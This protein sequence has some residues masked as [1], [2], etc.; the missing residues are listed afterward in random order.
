MLDKIYGYYDNIIYFDTE[1]TG[2]DPVENQIIELS[3]IPTSKYSFDDESAV[4]HDIY[5]NGMVPEEIV[6]LTGITQEILNEKGVDEAEM[7]KTF[8]GF[9]PADKKNLLIAHNAQFD[10]S[11]IREAFRRSGMET[12]IDGCDY[13]DTLTVFKDRRP[14]PHKLS[15]AIIDYDLS[16]VKNSHLAAD[17]TNALLAVTKA[18]AMERDDLD[19]YINIFG[20]NPKYGVSGKM[21]DKVRYYPQGFIRKMTSQNHTLPAIF[22]KAIEL[23]PEKIHVKAEAISDP[24]RERDLSETRIVIKGVVED[25]EFF[26]KTMNR[27]FPSGRFTIVHGGEKKGIDVFADQYANELGVKKAV[28]VPQWKRY[29]RKAGHV[30]NAVMLKYAAEK[31]GYFVTFGPNEAL[32]KQ[33]AKKGVKIINV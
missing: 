20:Y 4:V 19:R 12:L 17:D 30:R 8:A 21:L 24:V 28:F 27:L 7:V 23:V 11:F 14:Y 6:K 22:G 25:Y 13:L 18:M 26:K 16:D 9:L 31:N 2:F 1:T 32:A 33:A 3:F 15:D 10:I 29:K 5:V